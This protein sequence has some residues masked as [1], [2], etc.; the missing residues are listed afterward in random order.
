MV[1]AAASAGF[2]HS[3]GW[4]QNYPKI[5]ILTI[6]QL[7]DGAKINM[8]ANNQPNITFKQAERVKNGGSQ[9]GQLFGE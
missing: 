7:L 8:P 2:Y 3:P 9:Q 4:N 1:Q 5:Q 6:Q